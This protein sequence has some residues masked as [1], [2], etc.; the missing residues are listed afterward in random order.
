MT[1]RLTGD[2]P[3]VS[4]SFS[5]PAFR[6]ILVSFCALVVLAVVA[7]VEA[8]WEEECAR[9]PEM[10]TLEQVIP[11]IPLP[12]RW[13]AEGWGDRERF[14]MEVE[15]CGQRLMGPAKVED[16]GGALKTIPLIRDD[17][18]TY[19]ARFAR[20]PAVVTWSVE[21]DAEDRMTGVMTIMGRPDDFELELLDGKLNPELAGCH[22]LAV[23]DRRD[24]VEE[25][26]EELRQRP[27]T[28]VAAATE[29]GGVWQ[30]DAASC[31]ISEGTLDEDF[32]TQKSFE[33]AASAAYRGELVHRDRCCE[34]QRAHAE[35]SSPPYAEWQDV[36]A[37]LAVDVG[38]AY[39]EELRGLE[40]WL[41]EHCATDQADE[42]EEE[43]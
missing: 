11:P 16:R 12:G 15:D 5:P 27:G 34:V 6:R 33:A 22:C 2:R 38:V 7:P 30:T 14:D 36:E 8:Q 32:P 40:T 43:G 26:L 28:L 18:G 19:E 37:N 1:T 9:E 20:G 3:T 24:G 41:D 39:E 42:A 13:R 23:A 35:G 31:A 29:E 10:P 4:R 21:A 17:D 25:I